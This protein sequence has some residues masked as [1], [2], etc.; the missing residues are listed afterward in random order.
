MA[1][2]APIIR[3]YSLS[4][5]FGLTRALNDISFEAPHGIVGLVG[6]NGAGKTTLIRILLG[7]LKPSFGTAEVLGF[8]IRKEMDA[9]RKIVGYM[10]EKDSHIPDVSAKRYCAHLAQLNGL[11]RTP[12]LQRSHDILSYVGVGEERHRKMGTYSKGMLQKVKLAQA[13]VHS[14]EILFLDEPTDGLDPE[15]RL[16]MLEIIKDLSNSG[17]SIFLSTHILPDIEAIGQHLLVIHEGRL[18]FQDSLSK[19]LHHFQ[20][21]FRVDT[22]SDASGFCDKLRERGFTSEMMQ[23]PEEGVFV[24]VPHEENFDLIYQAARESKIRIVG[25]QPRKV[26]LQDAFVEMFRS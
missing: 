3:T 7:L 5:D 1:S 14:P 15:S 22:S 25:V 13:L 23:K 19:I 6:A 24:H 4:K 26:S 8:D 9:I 16:H 17:K 18:H 20:D 12:S 21:M 2:A 11:P 10:A